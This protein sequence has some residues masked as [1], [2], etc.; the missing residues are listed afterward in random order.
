MTSA[1]TPKP[2]SPQ[3][4]EG[5]EIEDVVERYYRAET[6]TA[7]ESALADLRT[8][9]PEHQL[10]WEV[11][12]VHAELSL[13][14]KGSA[15]AA[16]HGLE[17][18]TSSDLIPIF[19]RILGEWPLDLRDRWLS[20]ALNLAETHSNLS[21]RAALAWSIRHIS[22]YRGEKNPYHKASEILGPLL[23]LSII[24]TWDND[25]GKGLDIPYPPEEKIDLKGRYRGKLME[26]GWREEYPLDQRGKVNLDQLLYPTQWQVAYA[27]TAVEFEEAGSAELRLS[28][29]DPLRVWVNGVEV[30]SISRLEGW[31]FDGLI[32]PIYLRRGVNQILIKSA[33]KTGSWI[34]SARLTKPQGAPI[35]YTVRPADTPATEGL[36]PV[37]RLIKDEDVVTYFEDLFSSDMPAR[38]A[39]H[40]TDILSNLGL[41]VERLKIAERAAKEY[42]QSIL[43]KLNHLL[44]LWAQDERGR[45]ADLLNSLHSEFGQQA[46]LLTE[47]Q[48]RFW[49]QQHL[50][51]KARKAARALIK[52]RPKL[53]KPKVILAGLYQKKGWHAERCQLL[54]DAIEIDPNQLN[55]V[56][57]LASCEGKLGLLDA[58]WE[59]RRALDSITPNSYSALR[60]AYAAAKARRDGAEMVHI[61]QKCVNAWAQRSHCYV[62]LTRAL[63]MQGRI[64]ETLKTLDQLKRLNPTHPK[65]YE[66]S[67]SYLMSLDQ[68]DLALEAWTRALELDPENRKLSLRLT[69]AQPK[70]SEPWLDDVPSEDQIRAVIKSRKEIKPEQGANSLYLIDDDVTLLKSDGSTSSVTTSVTLALNQVGR[71]KLTKMYIGRGSSTQLMAAYAINPDDTRVEASSIR[72][73]VVRFRQ[74]K[75]GS[76]VVLQY[77][78]DSKP[79]AYLTGH[80]TRRWWFHQNK[81]QAKESRLVLWRPKGTPLNEHPQGP[82]ERTEDVRGEFVR[83]MWRMTDVPPVITEPKMPPLFS[84]V[85]GLQISTVP[86]WEEVWRWERELLRDVFRM[87]PEVELL[88]DE[89]LKDLKTPQ[90]KIYKIHEYVMKNIRYQQDYEHTI[91]GVKPHTAAQV[92][93]RQYGDCKDKAVLFITL[94]KRAGIDAH[95]ATVRTRDAGPVAKEIPS[96][97]FNH[98]IVFVPAQEG[99]EEG[100]FYD[101]TVD[102]LDVQTLRTDDQGTLSHVYN[103]D[104]EDHYWQEIPYQSE[105]MN[106]TEDHMKLSLT[107]EGVIQGELLLR[108]RGSIG[109]IIRKQARNPENFKQVMQYRVNQLMAGAE[110]LKHAPVKVDDLY[111]PAEAQIEFKHDN[112]V[113]REGDRLRIPALIDWSPKSLFHLE[114]R[115][116]PLVMG[117]NRKWTWF[118]TVSLPED[119]EISH[120]PADKTVGSECLSLSRSLKLDHESN[121]LKSTWVF[122]S[123][124]ERLSPEM[125]AQH[126]PIAREMMQLLSQEVEVVPKAVKVDQME[127]TPKI[128]TPTQ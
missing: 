95:F 50:D 83:V 109:Q 77:R 39:F 58:Q 70:G 78:K 54:R 122:K 25:Q 105:E 35:K 3:A 24:G 56:Q 104:Q 11:E 99:I 46:P 82:I 37:A 108:G 12:A 101:P 72:D 119:M 2:T 64:E 69:E 32:I 121:A 61:G 20:R 9:A 13:D 128:N 28:S 63:W 27:A 80:I 123:L 115:R 62:M 1:E 23:P 6:Y 88:S 97:Q 94:A 85:F 117:H 67:G 38:R 91:A 17:A 111:N 53:S 65:S 49:T 51:I 8:L 21:I 76:T 36:P 5:S 34:L 10:R 14:Y 42:P 120:L 126:R 44:A 52:M 127:A 90:E 26:I 16:F 71:D 107:K 106:F 31:M 59:R 114:E 22:H 15:Q 112:W 4:K 79:S 48:I 74:L 103:P 116:Y 55:I 75:I 81:T 7:L 100:R 98:A 87:S 60:R 102:E 93:S 86:S 84:Q 66:I 41:N 118:A 113:K 125:Y 40:T 45:A 47:F 73:G 96:Q 92:L 57:D 110:M 19:N 68:K 33:Q 43:I 18:G 89:L 124:C 29:S 30:L